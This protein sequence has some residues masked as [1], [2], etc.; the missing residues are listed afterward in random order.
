M[1]VITSSKHK[2][3]SLDLEEASAWMFNY[4]NDHVAQV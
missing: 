4:S 1:T 3:E 2:S